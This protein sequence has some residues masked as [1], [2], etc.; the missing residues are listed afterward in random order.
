[1]AERYSL[2]L[3]PP[4]D[5]AAYIHLDDLI[6]EHT[7]AYGDTPVFPPHITVAGGLAVDGETASAA[8]RRLAEEHAPLDITLTRPHCSTTWF[9]CVYLL[10]EPTH[11]L[12]QL[13]A[14]A[15]AAFN[16]DGD[17]YVPHLSLVYGD[18]PLQE[19]RQL[20]DGFDTTMLPLAFTAETLRL[21]ETSGGVADWAAVD[22]YT[23]G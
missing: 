4:E 20:V 1:M 9:Q 13:H 19:R 23:L 8:A 14:D 5:S 18:L 22:D 16:E 21:V 17:M 7:A 15:L 10:V 11:H 3:M 6:E 12:L 2:W